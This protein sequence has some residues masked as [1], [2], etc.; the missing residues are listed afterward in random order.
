VSREICQNVPALAIG[1]EDSVSQQWEEVTSPQLTNRKVIKLSGQKSLDI[2]RVDCGKKGRAQEILLPC[3]HPQFILYRNQLVGNFIP[4][5]SFYESPGHVNAKWQFVWPLEGG[6][7]AEF[8]CL[9][10]MISRS[11][12]E[13]YDFV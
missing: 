9:T 10:G 8:R 7:A 4:L 11:N 13:G 1:G 12:D 3:W 2:L 5:V 6:L